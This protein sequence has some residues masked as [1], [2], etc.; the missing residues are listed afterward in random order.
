MQ[1]QV[2]MRSFQLREVREQN[3]TLSHKDTHI[4][5][6]LHSWGSAEVNA[7]VTLMGH[8]ATAQRCTR[9]GGWR[10]TTLQLLLSPPAEPECGWQRQPPMGGPDY[11]S[12]QFH[13]DLSAWIDP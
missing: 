12:S 13:Q 1:S 8:C 5:S 4:A 3:A 9:L 11:C 7:A 6:K 2:Y 10:W